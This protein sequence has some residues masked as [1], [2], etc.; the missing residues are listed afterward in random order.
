L[1][2]VIF[3]GLLFVRCFH[4]KTLSDLWLGILLLVMCSSLITHFIGFA[5]VYDNNQWLTFFPFQIVFAHAPLIYLYVKTLTNEKRGFQ[6]KDL[7]LFIPTLVYWIYFFVL[8]LQSMEFKDWYGDNINGTYVTPFL[9]VSLFLWNTYFLYLSIK[10]YRQ[11]RSW[12]DENFSD[13]ELIKFNWLRNFLYIFAILFLLESVFD[14]IGLFRNI[15]YIQA[16]YLKLVIALATYYL[17]IAGYLR[18]KT[19]EIDFSPKEIETEESPKSLLETDELESSKTKL[20]ELMETEKPYLDSQLTLKELSKKLG[21]NTSV[22]SHTI[23]KGFNK[24]FNDFINEYRIEEVKKILRSED[25]N[26]ETFLSIAFDCGFNS[27]ATFNR[28]FKK[29]TGVSPKEFQEQISAD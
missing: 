15:S 19:I 3:A 24:N 17:A 2:G 9:D 25:A 23:N 18:S 20:L 10:Y 4:K 7:L 16:Y 21:V 29:F 6:I 5:N 13:T 22:L 1:Q 28:S 12:L 26:D 11:Y 8:F 14:V 27:K